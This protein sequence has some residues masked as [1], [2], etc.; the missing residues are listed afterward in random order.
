MAP[1]LKF[2]FLEPFFG[3][4]HREFAE[5]WVAHSRHH[6]DL[7]TLPARFWK[8]RMRGAALHFIGKAPDLAAYDGLIVTDLMSLS[9]FKALAGGACPPA[10]VYFHENQ[11]SYP[12]APG[13]QMDYQ[14]GFT[15]ITTALAAN[16]VVFNSHTHREAFFASLPRFLNMMP[17]HAP[18]WVVERIRAKSDVLHPGCRM[19]AETIALDAPDGREPPLIIWN[20]RWEFDKDPE[21]FYQA[22]DAM[23]AH[24]CDF[25]LA[26]LGERSRTAPPCFDAARRRY[27]NRIVHYGYVPARADYVQWLRRGHIVISTALQ[28]NFGIA[29]VEAVRLGCIPLLPA[30]LSY[31][32]II[33]AAFHAEVL[34]D[35]PAALQEKLAALLSG[36]QR[37][38]NLRR[39]LSAAMGRFSWE[40]SI[41]RFD[42]FLV[43]AFLV[44][45]LLEPSQKP[46]KPTRKPRNG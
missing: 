5:G 16:R 27:G 38:E 31:P 22:L 21:A 1:Q 46:K 13:E 2:L 42:A 4:S 30:R 11:F 25:R 20:H 3:G 14:F 19:P 26:L 36:Y 15:D 28:E 6:L 35:T 45:A 8:W 29:V 41:D 39:D 43:D 18:K 9:D 33:P 34:Y 44:D 7:L 32:E 40:R 23:P 10:L 37:F 17:D 24:G 12:L